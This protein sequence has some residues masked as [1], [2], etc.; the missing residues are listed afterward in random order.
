[1]STD[2]T[3]SNT[4]GR[5]YYIYQLG[6]LTDRLQSKVDALENNYKNLQYTIANNVATIGQTGLIRPYTTSFIEDIN[7]TGENLDIALAGDVRTQFVNTMYILY[8]LY[9]VHQTDAEAVADFKQKVINQLNID[10]AT[11]IK[12]NPFKV[13]EITAQTAF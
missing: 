13:N 12:N 7:S 6:M 10:F 11:K 2:N 1:M 5:E 3:L 4:M 8:E 9:Y